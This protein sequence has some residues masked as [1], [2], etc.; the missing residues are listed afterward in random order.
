MYYVIRHKAFIERAMAD[1][2]R[3]RDFMSSGQAQAELG[4]SPDLDEV[5]SWLS[6][7]RIEA[8][9]PQPLEM[10]LEEEGALPDL[11]EIDILLLSSRFVDALRAGGAD[12]LQI[13][14]LV[15][16]GPESEITTH[17]AVNVVGLG[18][19]PGEARPIFRHRETHSLYVSEAMRDHL[20]A[21]GLG[22]AIAFEDP[23]D[24]PSEEVLRDV[25]PGAARERSTRRTE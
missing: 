6:G 13:Y 23:E 12:N 2:A 14:D 16:R 20:I 24:S 11:I 21:S 7:E 17:K 22:E 19:E 8:D 18:P 1:P 9:L 4:A 15:L 5:E 3:L 10:E 25:L